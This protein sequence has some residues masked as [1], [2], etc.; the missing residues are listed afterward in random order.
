MLQ[1]LKIGWMGFLVRYRPRILFD[2]ERNA[3]DCGAVTELGG[4][5]LGWYQ[6]RRWLGAG[7]TIVVHHCGH[8]R[9][10]LARQNLNEKTRRYVHVPKACLSFLQAI[11]LAIGSTLHDVL[12]DFDH[13]A[14]Q[15]VG[16]RRNVLIPTYGR[17]SDT[18]CKEFY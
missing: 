13:T 14:E 6:K 12:S 5:A 2:T 9:L 3:D 17:H 11:A 4:V 1:E 10:Q 7:R 16:C 18:K 15:T 8:V